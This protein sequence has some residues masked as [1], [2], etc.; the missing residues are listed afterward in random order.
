M[1]VDYV[2]VCI[3]A[4]PNTYMAIYIYVYIFTYICYWFGCVDIYIY[5]QANEHAC[6]HADVHSCVQA[7]MH[8]M[9]PAIQT[10]HQA[11]AG[12]SGHGGCWKNH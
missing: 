4:Y 8:S 3:Y 9:I 5:V 10:V 2:C 7:Y 6:M 11:R 12:K 1:C